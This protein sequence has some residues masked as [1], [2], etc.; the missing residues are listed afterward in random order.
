MIDFW[1]KHKV[2]ILATVTFHFALVLYFNTSKLELPERL[3]RNKVLLEIDYTEQEEELDEQ[4]PEELEEEQLTEE[5]IEEKIQNMMRDAQDRRKMSTQN[6]SEKE[7]E[8]QLEEKY[9][10]LEQDIIKKRQ[11]EGKGFDA[12]KYEIEKNTEPTQNSNT[13]PAENKVAGRVTREC[14]IPGRNCYAKTPSYRCPS[15]GKIHIDI[16]VNQKGKVTH[17]EYNASK[18]TSSN[19]CLVNEAIKY[20]KLSKANQDFNAPNTQGGYI[21]YNFISQ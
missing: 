4:T 18:S 17:A 15:G 2:G 21:I 14:N 10:Q 16:K 3:V 5:S 19:E 8:E 12:S 7:I 13:Q 11:E 9:K 6:F 20:A 1:K